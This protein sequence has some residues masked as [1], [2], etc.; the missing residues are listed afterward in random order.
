MK[1]EING[2]TLYHIQA[3]TEW[4]D[5][6]YDI[7]LWADHFPTRY[8]IKEAYIRDRFGSEEEPADND[9]EIQDFMESHN[10]YTIYA[11]EIKGE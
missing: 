2:K 6:P 7:F 9:T 3:V 10:V 11:E 1:V 8:E 4:S 5:D